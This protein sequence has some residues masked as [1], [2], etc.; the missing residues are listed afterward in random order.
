MK[1]HR[2]NK[3]CI[4]SKRNLIYM[5]KT[6]VIKRGDTGGFRKKTEDRRWWRGKIKDL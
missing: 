1:I 5:I 6:I 4:I 3:Q 2:H